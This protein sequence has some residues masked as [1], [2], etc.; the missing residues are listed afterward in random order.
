M[1][2]LS[3]LVIAWLYVAG[4]L[5]ALGVVYLGIDNPRRLRSALFI[6]LW[7][8]AILVLIAVVARPEHSE[9]SRAKVFE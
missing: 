2:L 9:H 7:P 3:I 4:A 1:T 5:L 8:V 6:V